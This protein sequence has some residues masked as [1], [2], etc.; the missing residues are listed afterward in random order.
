M[1]QSVADSTRIKDLLR[2]A[3][4]DEIDSREMFMKG[5]DYPYYYE[6]P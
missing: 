6:E 4:T 5:T 1:T 3:L 2:G